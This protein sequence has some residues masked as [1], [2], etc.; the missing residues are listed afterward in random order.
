MSPYFPHEAIKPLS[1]RGAE[2]LYEIIRERY[3]QRSIIVTSNRAPE[4]WADIFGNQPINLGREEE[5]DITQES[6]NQ[7]VEDSRKG[8]DT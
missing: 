7:E 3:E 8:G 5:N 6:H 1:A 4:E 2:D